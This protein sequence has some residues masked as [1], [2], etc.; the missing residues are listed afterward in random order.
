[1]GNGTSVYHD[2]QITDKLSNFIAEERSKSDIADDIHVSDCINEVR[3]LRKILQEEI[4]QYRISLYKN[5][6]IL[7]E[8]IERLN[9]ADLELFCENH[10]ADING[11]ACRY[12]EEDFSEVT[13]LYQAASLGLAE[14]VDMLCKFGADTSV[15]RLNDKSSALFGAATNGHLYVIKLLILRYEADVN[16]ANEHGLT[17]LLAAVGNNHWQAAS[18]LIDH[19]ASIYACGKNDETCIFVAS[20]RNA[21]ESLVEIMRRIAISTILGEIITEVIMSNI[22]KYIP[23]DCLETFHYDYPTKRVQIDNHNRKMYAKMNGDG[24]SF[25]DIALWQCQTESVFNQLDLHISTLLQATNVTR[26]LGLIHKETKFGWKA[27]HIASFMGHLDIVKIIIRNGGGIDDATGTGLTPL[28]LAIQNGQNHVTD[29]LR[30]NNAYQFSNIFDAAKYGNTRDIKQF[31]KNG[32]YDINAIDPNDSNNNIPLTYACRHGKLETVQIILSLGGNYKYML[33]NR[34]TALFEA[35]HNNHTAI[36]KYLWR[37]GGDIDCID[38]DKVCPLVFGAKRNYLKAVS[39][40]IRCGANLA[41]RDKHGR[42]AFFYACKNDNVD[43]IDILV[44]TKKIDI[45]AKDDEGITP[46]MVACSHGSVKAIKRLLMDLNCYVDDVSEAGFMATDYARQNTHTCQ[47]AIMEVFM[48]RQDR[49]RVYRLW[50]RM[51]NSMKKTLEKESI[52][53]RKILTRRTWKKKR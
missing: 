49:E 7:H 34:R 16:L 53:H 15:G 43:A 6:D 25:T 21:I 11:Y 23:L 17:P 38:Q 52:T 9:L 19:G 3:R 50:R 18:F 45:E 41:L 4:L 20:H 12:G 28:A 37:V 13:P 14:F 30:S 22:A 26:A 35:L 40:C 44:S 46:L 33:A 27:I 47:R 51:L 8:A 39:L 48:S 36:A 2:L 31:V 42:D 24:N 32:I 10:L 1:M 5:K 29:Y